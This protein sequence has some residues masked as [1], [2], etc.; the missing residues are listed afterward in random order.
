LGLPKYEGELAGVH[1]AVFENEKDIP[2]YVDVCGI[3]FFEK[4]SIMDKVYLTGL[5]YKYCENEMDNISLIR[6]NYEKRYLLDYLT[7]QFSTHQSDAI[8]DSFSEL[9]IP[10]MIKLYKHYRESEELEEM[11]NIETLLLKLSAKTD[12]LEMVQEIIDEK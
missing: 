2:V 4:D 12:K 7:H 11:K 9:Y 3:K 5:A 1:K 10:S 8:G 6:R